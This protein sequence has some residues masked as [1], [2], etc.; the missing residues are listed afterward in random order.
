M[1]KYKYYIAWVSESDG[2]CGDDTGINKQ[3]DLIPEYE[4]GNPNVTCFNIKA[5]NLR[6]AIDRGNSMAF[7]DNFTGHD[8][9]TITRKA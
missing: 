8:T 9:V 3:A 2:A 5:T 7:M 4:K 6:N 1:K